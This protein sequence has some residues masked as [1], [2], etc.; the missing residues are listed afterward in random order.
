[1]IIEPG[2]YGVDPHAGEGRIKSSVGRGSRVQVNMGR[3]SRVVTNMASRGATPV[4]EDPQKQWIALVEEAVMKLGPMDNE[5]LG[6]AQS[7][8]PEATKRLF[9]MHKEA[10][11]GDVLKAHAT[12]SYAIEK[13]DADSLDR[14]TNAIE[15]GYVP[16]N[17]QFAAL[18]KLG[19][20]GL[21]VIT[22]FNDV[23]QANRAA[24]V[25]TVYP[26]SR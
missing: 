13:G 22:K 19:K 7:L 18:Q 25:S 4:V 6:Y 1:M 16:D 11:A 9:A 3:E 5:H 2:S 10:V 23:L 17:D 20:P 8:D 14:V 24:Q 12:I 26:V 15:K 21:D